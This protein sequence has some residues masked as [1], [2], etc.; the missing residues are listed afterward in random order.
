MGA[1]A[2]DVPFRT[3]S[4]TC[5]IDSAEHYG[6]GA[7]MPGSCSRKWAV[8]FEGKATI[9]VGLLLRVHRHGSVAVS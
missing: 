9:A 6:S 4:C 7:G 2:A 3:H 8:W 5:F 1:A